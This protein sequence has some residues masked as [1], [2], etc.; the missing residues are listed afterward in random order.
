[1]NGDEHDVDPNCTPMLNIATST[2]GG[3][4]LVKSG[5]ANGLCYAKK[6]QK[7]AGSIWHGN[8]KTLDECMSKCTADSECKFFSFWHSGWCQLDRVC[9][10][11]GSSG[12]KMIS[13]FGRGDGANQNQCDD[14]LN[15]SMMRCGGFSVRVMW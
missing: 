7:H 1:M 14:R 10:H 11:W 3:F 5:T 8:A 13:T 12:S 2:L 9:N 15:S 4:A 6:D